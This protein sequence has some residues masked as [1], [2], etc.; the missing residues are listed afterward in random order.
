MDSIKCKT[1]GAELYADSLF[2]DN[3]GTKA[4]DVLSAVRA[5]KTEEEIAK[6]I[7]EII[8]KDNVSGFVTSF[9]INI[10]Q[11]QAPYTQ[12]AD[13]Q[14]GQTP[15]TKRL[16]QQSPVQ[17]P[18]SQPTASQPSG[19]APYAERTVQQPQAQARYAQERRQQMQETQQSNKKGIARLWEKFKNQPIAVKIAIIGVIVIFVASIIV[20]AVA[21]ATTV[22]Q[23]TP[24]EELPPI[25]PPVEEDAFTAERLSIIKDGVQ[26]T[27]LDIEINEIVVLHIDV[28]PLGLENNISWSMARTGI[29]EIMSSNDDG[30]E[31]IIEG[32]QSGSVRLTASMHGVETV[33]IVRVEEDP[34]PEAESVYILRNGARITAAEVFEGDE[35]T[36]QIEVYPDGV[37]DEIRVASSNTATV[38]IVSIRADGSDVTI[39]GVSPGTASITVSV[40]RQRIEC[41]ITVKDNYMQVPHPYAEALSA[42]NEDAGLRRYAYLARIPGSE[43]DSVLAFRLISDDEN[44]PLG[45]HRGVHRLIFTQGNNLRTQDFNW[46]QDIGGYTILSSNNHL[47]SIF[48]DSNPYG[49]TSILQIHLFVDG[50]LRLREVTLS[51]DF[52][53]EGNPIR[54]R[55]GNIEI[56][57]A[58]Y[59]QLL[60]EF[61]LVNYSEMPPRNDNTEQILAMTITVPVPR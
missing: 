50:V 31:I 46:H 16:D 23:D 54:Y 15:Y 47:A 38:Q 3:C 56:D 36:L 32:L 29:V 27:S 5:D 4:D 12:Q 9:D 28:Y 20:G 7:S 57:Q 17:I 34:P 60:G 30:T 8:E 42:F 39:R 35:L 43:A 21:L 44:A 10:K 1:C 26:I 24:Q 14:P 37:E 40:G 25:E 45:T 33:L 13:Q 41:T 11:P 53:E 19:Q 18:Y 61:G 49:R 52:D 51:V 59:N 55:H 48:T 58:R 22:R 2:C 6:S